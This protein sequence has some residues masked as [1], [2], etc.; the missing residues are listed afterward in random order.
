MINDAC[1]PG[2][3]FHVYAFCLICSHY[4]FFNRQPGDGNILQPATTYEKSFTQISYV[5]ATWGDLLYWKMG[6]TSFFST[7]TQS[8]HYQTFATESRRNHNEMHFSIAVCCIAQLL[9]L[10]D[11]YCLCIY[12]L[13][14]NYQ[15]AFLTHSDLMIHWR[16]LSTAY[17]CP[18]SIKQIARLVLE[19]R[20]L[21]LIF[22]H[23]SSITERTTYEHETIKPP[24]LD[25]CTMTGLLAKGECISDN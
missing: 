8:Y 2:T 10:F 13:D 5:S 12:N 22:F 17:M 20:I 4:I 21:H 23:I 3:P 25:S 14:H 7:L 15:N 24:I 18:Q 16:K 11:T 1:C 19:V 9:S 6:A